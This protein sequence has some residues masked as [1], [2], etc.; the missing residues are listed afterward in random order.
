MQ[1]ERSAQYNHT[2]NRRFKRIFVWMVRF[3]SSTQPNLYQH[4]AE[5]THFRPLQGKV[6]LWFSPILSKCVSE[7]KF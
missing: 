5:Q 3:R 1:I 6:F 7:F 4:N 2:L